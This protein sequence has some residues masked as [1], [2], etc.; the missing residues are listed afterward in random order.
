MLG[1]VN[2]ILLTLILLFVF[3]NPK[4]KKTRFTK[5]S[6]TGIFFYTQNR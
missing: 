6:K 5:N 4:K 2:Y 3:L 1:K